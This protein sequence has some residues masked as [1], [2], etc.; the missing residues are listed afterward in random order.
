MTTY[1]PDTLHRFIFE[2]I[3]ARGLIVQLNDCWKALQSRKDYPAVVQQQ[4]GEFIAA[5]ALLAA[6]LKLNGSMTMQIQSDGP[7]NLMVMEC[8]SEKQIRGLAK[9]HEDVSG[10]NL[11][12]LFG[13]GQLVITIDN[14]KS[15]ERYQGIVE[16]KGEK[17]SH[18]LENYLK[19]SEQL[20]TFLFLAANENN[21]CGI[22]IQKMPGELFEDT[23]DWIRINQQKP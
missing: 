13:D 9:Y 12:E 16:L 4:L 17:I 3:P 15:N 14:A 6:S 21:A 1:T 20:E 11:S 10:D 8:N 22:L 2:N 23:D 18:A 7:I 19:Q 5:N